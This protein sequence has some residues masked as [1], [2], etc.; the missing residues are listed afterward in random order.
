MYYIDRNT[1]LSRLTC[2]LPS[3]CY[4]ADVLITSWASITGRGLIVLIEAGGS[5]QGFTH[6]QVISSNNGCLKNLN[7]EMLQS[8]YFFGIVETTQPIVKLSSL[9]SS[10]S[11]MILVLRT[12]LFPGIPMG[13]PPKFKGVGKI[14]ISDRLIARKRL[15][16]DGYIIY[17]AIRLT[18]IESSFS[19][20]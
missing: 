12:K 2:C 8:I 10:G 6:I 17:A 15:K 19:S 11:L 13:T 1:R 3:V 7:H 4:N 9:S 18:S 16:I 20:M 5:I 14:A